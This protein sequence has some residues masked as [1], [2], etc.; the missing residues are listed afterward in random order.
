ML[1]NVVMAM[2]FPLCNY[3]IMHYITKMHLMLI[4]F[5]LLLHN[6]FLQVG[7]FK[8][9]LQNYQTMKT[10][11]FLEFRILLQVI[12]VINICCKISLH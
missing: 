5:Q 4:T 6:K 11:I 8:I 3:N 12:S 7:H 9:L 1:C 2:F 10:T